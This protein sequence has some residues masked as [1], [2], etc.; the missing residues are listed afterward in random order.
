MREG[1]LKSRD[2]VAIL[3]KNL[4]TGQELALSTC[5]CVIRM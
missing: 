3:V 1:V 2:G 5:R 4:D